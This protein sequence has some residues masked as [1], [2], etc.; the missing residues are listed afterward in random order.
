MCIHRPWWG[1]ESKEWQALGNA[2]ACSAFRDLKSI[3]NALPNSL[4]VGPWYGPEDETVAAMARA[5]AHG[6]FNN[7]RTLQLPDRGNG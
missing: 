5:W 2:H 4:Q 6:L 1:A 3:C 7:S